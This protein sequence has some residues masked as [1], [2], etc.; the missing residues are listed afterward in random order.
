MPYLMKALESEYGRQ[1]IATLVNDYIEVYD[2][3][4]GTFEDGVTEAQQEALVMRYMEEVFADV[5]GDI[6]RGK[7]RTTEAEL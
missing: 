4:Y 3:I 6:R 5:Y 7:H 2:G 1:E